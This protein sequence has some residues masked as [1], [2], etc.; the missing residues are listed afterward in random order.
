MVPYNDFVH[1]WSQLHPLLHKPL[2]KFDHQLLDKIWLYIHPLLLARENTHPHAQMIPVGLLYLSPKLLKHYAKQNQQNSNQT[3]HL[4]TLLADWKPKNNFSM[5][6][7]HYFES[8]QS[9]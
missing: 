3:I 4:P 5:V 7:L 9:F 1:Y 2:T 8:Q 6:Y